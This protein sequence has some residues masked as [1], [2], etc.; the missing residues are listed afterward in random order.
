MKR[1][2]GITAVQTISFESDDF[3]IIIDRKRSEGFERAFHED[4]EIKYFFEGSSAV[5]IN[6][7]VYIA[8]A[9]SIAVVNP[10][11]IHTNVDT[12]HHVG[13]YYLIIIS[14]DFFPEHN[15]LGIDLRRIFI[16]EG[17]RIMNFIAKDERIASVIT[18]AFEEISEKKEHYKLVV[19]GLMSELFVLLLRSYVRDDTAMPNAHG[20]GKRAELI[21]PA[22]SMIF[23]EYRR[24]ISLDELAAACNISKFHFT[25]LFE[26][27]MGMSPFEYLK[28]Y[29]ISL[30]AAMLESGA[31]SI[32]EVAE[33][34]GFCDLSY[35][36]RCYKKV[37][38]VTP[39]AR[40]KA[41]SSKN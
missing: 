9:G 28:S 5:L 22:L 25:R 41:I 39:S 13:K 7:E 20:R 2:N 37:R 36:Y 8:E 32:A 14:M 21:S 40:K 29:R 10:Y 11:E 26:Q 35:F 19:Q 23:K 17:K 34:C 27:E 12:L 18:R 31:Q 15:P 33:R 4:I 1:N 16:S 30:A 3:K 24:K 6:D 38:G